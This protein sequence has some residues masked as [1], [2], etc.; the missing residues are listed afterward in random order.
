MGNDAKRIESLRAEINEHNRRYYVDAKPSIGDK[1]FDDLLKQLEALEASHPELITPDSP[2]Q[3]VGGEPISSFN[4]VPHARPMLSIDN[5][6]DRDD[7]NAWHERVL[8]RLEVEANEIAYVAEPKIDGVAV[9]L[10]YEDS[11]L[12]LATSR[13]DGQRGDDITQNVRTIKAIPLKLAGDNVPAILEVRGEI[14]IP[15]DEFVRINE[16]R[17]EAGEERYANPRNL[18]AGTLKQLDA[19]LVAERRMLFFAHGLGE[20]EPD[21]FSLYSDYLNSIREWGLPTNPL[22]QQC[23]TI[24]DVWQAIEAFDTK[25]RDLTYGVDGVV[26]K[27]NSRSQQASLGVRSKSPRWCIAYKYA[28]EQ[29]TTK[30]IDVTWQVGKTGRLTPRATMEPVFLAGTT[31]QHATLHNYDEIQ[32]KDIHVGDTVVIE[33]AGEIIP[34][35]IEVKTDLRDKSSS[36]IEPPH[37]CPSCETPVIKIDEEVDYRCQNPECPAQL[38]ERLI[39]FSGR[40][41]MDIDGL[42]EKMIHQ[43]ADADLIASF[44]DIFSLKQHRD[45]LLELERMGEKKVDNLL[46]SIETAK[47]RGLRRVLAGLGI[48]HIGSGGSKALSQHF[49]NIDDLL[50][51]NEETLADIPDIGPITAQS[52]FEFFHCEAGHHVIDELKEAGLDLTEPQVAVVDA[53]A[54]DSPFAGK[55]VVIT[56][57]LE[58]FG[59][60]ELAVQL[61][62]LGAKVSGSISAKTD[63]LIAGE[64]AGSKLDKAQKLGIEIWDEEKLLTSLP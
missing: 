26:V 1:A 23:T 36:L 60:K 4:T 19:R 62:S 2:T 41:Q 32:R 21:A 42:G 16:Q 64:K 25:R 27:V 52:V 8:K 45:K 6:Y 54:F 47:G 14:V 39:W 43:L 31:V 30:L 58:K 35:V 40:D 12:V 55:T 63:I 59:R 7:L 48:R 46:A 17:E 33:K 20:L 9:N 61:E 53:A 22:T 56:G 3:R 29:A 28:A 24:D 44:G 50:A 37:I 13:G 11:Q 10:R 51:A 34:Q 38:R 49:G 15:D 5:T 57:T 18:T